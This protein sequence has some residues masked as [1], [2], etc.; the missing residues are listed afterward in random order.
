LE[1]LSEII[2]KILKVKNPSNTQPS[3]NSN[4]PNA[5]KKKGGAQSTNSTADE[6]ITNSPSKMKYPL[7]RDKKDGL[8]FDSVRDIFY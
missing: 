3:R 1:P 6:S 4:S 8:T 2:A 5:R 7:N